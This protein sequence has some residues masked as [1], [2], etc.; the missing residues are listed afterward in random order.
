MTPRALFRRILCPTDFSDASRAALLHAI[1]MARWCEAEITVVHVSPILPVAGIEPAAAV[2]MASA[3][4][5]TWGVML[6]DL[7]DFAAPA[8]RAG[9]EVHTALLEGE[10]VHEILGLAQ[11]ISA[12]IIVMGTHGRSG[13]NRWLLGS[14]AE[15]L[16]RRSACPVVTVSHAAAGGPARRDDPFGTIVCPVDLRGASRATLEFGLA[17]ARDEGASLTLLHVV[18]A[19]D[20]VTDFNAHFEIPEHR[21]L[22][23]ADARSRLEGAVPAELRARCRVSEVVTVG[24]PDREILRVA[25]ERHADLIVMGARGPNP[26]DALFFGSTARRVVRDAPCPVL[27]LPLSDAPHAGKAP[28]SKEHEELSLP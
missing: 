12:D 20:A 26:I 27:T 17:L 13:V 22:L 28:E 6:D 14:V 9:L 3:S 15:S 23:A 10:A 18:E 11:G 2:S 24:R 5:T 7:S 1:S 19:P 8:R 21:A 25:E 4:E 16:L